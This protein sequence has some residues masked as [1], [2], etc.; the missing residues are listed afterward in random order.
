MEY[1]KPINQIIKER[2]SWRTYT[3]KTLKEK[4]LNELKDFIEEQNESP[5]EGE[6]RVEI[7]NI[8]EIEDE[9]LATLGFVKDCPSYIIGA[10]LK[11]EYDSEHY[12]YVFEKII[13]KATELGLGTCWIGGTFDKTKAKQL[14]RLREDEKLPAISPLGYAKKRGLKGRV[15]R[16]VI[17]SKK[18]K[19]WSELFFLLDQEK[20]KLHQLDS[21]NEK[22]TPFNQPLE[23]VRLG[24]SAK[25]GQPWRLVLEPSTEGS[26]PGKY[27]VHFFRH[28]SHQYAR[29]DIS[30]A[31]CHFDLMR[32]QEDI[33]GSWEFENS[34]IEG[35]KQNEIIPGAWLYTITFKTK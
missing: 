14:I 20:R 18:R 34:R 11:D 21:E 17:K 12:G 35:L 3:G 19:P 25:N 8:N 13:L 26:D 23:M 27:N 33:K 5:F 32:I 7:I 2:S 28:D 4:T 6:H 30:I 31:V 22:I 9:K 15:I 29:L 24:P 16:W 10:V 1:K